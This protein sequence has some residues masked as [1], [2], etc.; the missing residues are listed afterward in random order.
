MKEKSRDRVYVGD[1]ILTNSNFKPIDNVG[2]PQD[3]FGASFYGVVVSRRGDKY[4]V[5]FGEGL[6]FTNHLDGLLRNPVGYL[7]SRDEFDIPE[8]F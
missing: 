6:D 7:L 2:K 3:L 4:G 1:I 8:D 5:R